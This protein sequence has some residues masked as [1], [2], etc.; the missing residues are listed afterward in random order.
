MLQEIEREEF[1]SLKGK[2][3]AVAFGA[4]QTEMCVLETGTIGGYTQRPKPPFRLV[5]AAAPDCPLRQGMIQF[6]HPLRG[7]L[8][9]FVTC[10]GADAGGTRYEAVFN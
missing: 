9:I 8:E 7:R 3:L 1:E 2:A 10:I 4:Q 6:D 5:L